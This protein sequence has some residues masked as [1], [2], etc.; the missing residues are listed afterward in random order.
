MSHDSS[1]P[2][3]GSARPTT[4]TKSSQ[5]T[6]AR[7]VKG[8]FEASGG[9]REVSRQ[10]GKTHI[11]AATANRPKERPLDDWEVKIQQNEQLFFTKADDILGATVRGLNKEHLRNE[12]KTLHTCMTE[13]V[14]EYS[15][16]ISALTA[17]DRILEKHHQEIKGP[18]IRVFHTVKDE[19]VKLD[20]SLALN[21]SKA[22]SQEV[23][24][25]LP[26]AQN[27]IKEARQVLAKAR[28]SL[29]EATLP[30]LP[31]KPDL[32]DVKVHP[33]PKAV[34]RGDQVQQEWLKKK[35]FSFAK[36]QSLKL[37]LP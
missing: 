29:I 12:L 4:G 22:T 23:K 6:D 10:E 32:A 3:G 28:T 36:K 27:Q 21:A 33:V 20:K 35:D 25:V 14:S 5:Q 11:P 37:R 34:A 2:S 31:E 17:T 16:R 26:I 1:I 24:D 18:M 7:K 19:L 30:D 8:K 9:S 13:I 15:Q